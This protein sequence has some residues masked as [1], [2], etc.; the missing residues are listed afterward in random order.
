MLDHERLG[1]GAARLARKLKRA[2]H[3]HAAILGSGWSA[4]VE[5]L[6]VVDQVSYA[7]IP[8][9]GVPGVPGHPGRLI[10]GE[11][12]S[13]NVLVFAGRRHWYEGAG[14][15]PVAFPVR[16]CVELQCRSLL[17]TNAA[18]GIR[19]DLRPGRLMLISDHVNMMGDNPLRGR[20]APEWGQRFPGMNDV[21]DQ[22][23]GKLLSASAA[24]AG[25]PISPG[26]YLAIAGPNYETP[27][28][29][30]AFR[31]LGADAV[32]M[33]TVPEAILAHAAG[34]RICAVSCITNVAA[35]GG[36]PTHREVLETSAAAA[37][38]LAATLTGYWRRLSGTR[39]GT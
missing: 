8:E 38:L 33:S 36:N 4:A 3:C 11:A 29:I 18:G 6:P 17:I 10:V 26:V 20:H 22:S 34:L 2:G 27:A 16:L 21:Y 30:A 14:W 39:Q 1:N 35:A 19:P 24:E 13:A 25:I 32:G 31:S 7:D 12:G 28:E 9:L 5:G 15:D 37:P 23:L